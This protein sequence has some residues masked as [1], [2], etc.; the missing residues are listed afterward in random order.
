MSIAQNLKQIENRI[1]KAAK[2]AG[3]N[4]KKITLVVAGKYASDNQMGVLVKA[5][6]KVIGENREQDLRRKNSIYGP[7]VDWHFIGHLQRNKVKH[8]IKIAKLIH[9]VDSVRLIAELENQLSKINKKLPILLEVN[10][11]GETSKF[12]ASPQ[13][14]IKLAKQ[15]SQCRFVKLMGLMTM[16]GMVEH[17]EDNRK[18][19]RLLKNL[20]QKIERLKLPHIS[21]KHLS[22]GTTRDFEIAIE[23]GAT[24]VRVGSAVFN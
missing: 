17:A 21:M 20:A 2:R 15:C 1:H 24:L 10:T 8:V 14:V 4:P 6:A 13:E 5:G 23:E 19:F 16:G 12:G 7:K 3:R 11:A 18:N 9:S 22:M